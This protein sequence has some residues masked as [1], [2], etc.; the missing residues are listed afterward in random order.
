MQQWEEV[1]VVDVVD[2]QVTVMC[3]LMSLMSNDQ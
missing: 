1:V 2:G 3:P